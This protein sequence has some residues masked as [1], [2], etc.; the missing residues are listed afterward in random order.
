MKELFR[1]FL[2][3]GVAPRQVAGLIAQPTGSSIYVD[4][5]SDETS[6]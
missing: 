4:V 1:V 6:R 2:Y 5:R 3:V